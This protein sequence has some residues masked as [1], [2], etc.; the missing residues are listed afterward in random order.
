[1]FF[2]A[3]YI[4]MITVSALAV[5]MF[6]GGWR[7][8]FPFSRVEFLS[9][10]FFPI[11]WFLA[12][13]LLFIFFFVWL[14]GTLPR[15]RYDQFMRLGWKV[16][17]PVSLVWIMLV[18]TIRVLDREIE[19][20][21]MLVLVVAAAFAVILGIFAVLPQKDKTPEQEQDEDARVL[22]PLD[23]GGFPTP[24]IDLVVPPTNRSL[25]QVT[26]GPPEPSTPSSTSPSP[27][28]TS[29]EP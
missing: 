19:S 15:M 13:L 1:M 29:K 27:S 20:R 3:E 28:S 22:V 9:E 8:P 7:A 16:L 12:K 23:E 26:A 5:T 11:F 14:R 4:N 2:L 17:I 21:I 25:Q 24:P 18:A 6:L 10:G